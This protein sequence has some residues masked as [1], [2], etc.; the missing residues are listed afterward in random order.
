MSAKKRN[1]LLLRDKYEIIMKC[2][3]NLKRKDIINEYK[4]ANQSHL[5]NILKNKSKIIDSYEK[6]NP[7]SSKTTSYVR[8]SDY[9]DVEEAIVLW[10]RQMRDKKINLNSDLIL[11]KAREF[12][13]TM[14]YK[15]FIGSNRFIDGLKKRNN[16]NWIKMSGESDSVNPLVVQN[17]SK[18]LK[19]EV[20]G[21]DEKDVFN[22]D[23]TSLFYKLLPNKT[24]AFGKESKFG[25]KQRKD[26]ITVVL[27]CNTNGS[28]REAIIIGKSAKPRA[29]RGIQSPIDYYSQ[30]NAWM[31]AI[32][33]NKIL[34]K[35]DSKMKKMDRKVILFVD[36]CSSHSLTTTLTNISLKY[37]PPNATS[38]LQPLDQGIIRSFKAHYRKNI[39]SLMISNLENGVDIDSKQINLLMAMRL[40]SSSLKTIKTTVFINCFRKALFD[41]RIT[42]QIELAEEEFWSHLSS[43]TSIEFNSFEEF[44]SFDDN[45]C[46]ANGSDLTDE[47]IIQ[48][49]HST[50]DIE[51]V[52]DSDENDYDSKI[53]TNSEALNHLNSLQKFFWQSRNSSYDQF[54]DQMQRE[55]RD[56][57]LKSLKQTKVSDFLIKDYIY[58][59]FYEKM[60]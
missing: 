9:P 46:T 21:F 20:Q 44:V 29:L 54:F 15:N 25:R 39:V 18:K 30:S 50:G 28:Y 37:L 24:Y 41:F 36:N 43:L 35:F 47:Q 27:L 23:E 32:I 10:I 12:A 22:L 34:R 53:V 48:T 1:K 60:S 38:K 4:L 11:D 31:D 59:Y 45:E 57:A 3:N 8:S 56:N 49:V 19:K 58:R 51:E 16:I 5:T 26:R 52:I 7:K 40:I 2:E 13:Q 14:G 6:L 42:T 55:I 17:W 33:F